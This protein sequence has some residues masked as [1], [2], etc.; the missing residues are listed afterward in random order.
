MRRAPPFPHR[1]AG[2]ERIPAAGRVAGKIEFDS[3]R[4]RTAG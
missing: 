1:A 4:P 2:G 3:E